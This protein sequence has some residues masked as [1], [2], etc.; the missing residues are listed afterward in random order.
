[1]SSFFAGFNQSMLHKVFYTHEPLVVFSSAL[2][3]FSSECH[4]DSCSDELIKKAKTLLNTCFSA[5]PIQAEVSERLKF[6]CKEKRTETTRTMNNIIKHIDIN[7][8]ISECLE[9]V[10][11]NS[12]F[13]KFGL[14]VES[15]AHW[16]FLFK[17]I[18]QRGLDSFIVPIFKRE[19]R[20][21]YF[22][23]PII[24][25][26]PSSW[27]PELVILPP[28]E[29]VFFI[30]LLYT[31]NSKPYESYF[32][33]PNNNSIELSC[34][35][36]E[37]VKH[38]PIVIA[39]TNEFDQEFGKSNEIDSEIKNALDFDA[40]ELVVDKKYKYPLRIMN[41]VDINGR[42]IQIE[43]NK[44][45]IC[46]S[47]KGNINSNSFDNKDQLS[48]TAYIVNEID[49]SNVTEEDF[50]RAQNH[51]M[52]E[53]K[54]PLRASLSNPA[55]PRILKKLGAT[56]ANEQNI[57]NWSDSDRIA[58][59]SNNDFTAVLKFAGIEHESKIDK[60][61]K[62]ARKQRGKSISFGHSK[63]VLIHEIVKNFL[64][65]K[66]LD[67]SAYIANEYTVH[68]IKI[69]IFKLEEQLCPL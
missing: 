25:F 38:Q 49:N 63:S 9:S 2:K 1:M 43:A 61:F 18:Q 30:T 65:S 44:S 64:A 21:Q 4:G 46:V 29:N 39:S 69:H 58:P 6:L 3:R 7:L 8:I 47:N 45:Y 14:L 32:K 48:N 20:E 59:A 51:L 16:I 23:F 22:D 42:D 52:E 31:S 19:A 60:F 10:I 24:T 12:C 67:K 55:L 62:L 56:R 68:G 66:L 40:F 37:F 13:D 34:D 50:K 26:L 27:T 57:R 11:L 17:L 35:K 54:K 15:E 41:L 5:R 33:A 28:S 36:S 53:W